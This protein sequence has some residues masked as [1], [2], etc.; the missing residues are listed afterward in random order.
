MTLILILVVIILLVCVIGILCTHSN[1]FET[2]SNKQFPKVIY[3]YW[4]DDNIPEFVH[5]CM[6]TWR[7]FNP[8]YKINILNDKILN[9][10][11]NLEFKSSTPARKSDYAR[12]AVLA[13][14]GGFWLDASTI[15]TQSLDWINNI[16]QETSCE[17]FGFNA[18]YFNTNTEIPVIE[19]WFL[20]SIPKS[21]FMNDWYKEFLNVSTYTEDSDYVEAKKA[22]GIDLQNLGGMLPYLNIHLSCITIQQKNPNKYKLSHLNA[23]DGPFKYLQDHEWKDEIAID[24]LCRDVAYRM[25]MPIIKM[26]GQE[27][28]YIEEN[29]RYME[30]L[31][32]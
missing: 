12:L 9:E 15:C 28:K 16:Q 3:T 23:T 31:F 1:I 27:R 10:S 22:Q 26:R 11:F 13:R 6:N 24:R 4:D 25:S 19:S 8:D 29:P 21:K 7:Q 18:P 17:F 32:M 2:F 5:K 30:C 20:A 14:N